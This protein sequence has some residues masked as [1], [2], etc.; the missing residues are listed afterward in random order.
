MRL[1]HIIQR[2]KVGV[3]GHSRR[4]QIVEDVRHGD[5]AGTGLDHD[6]TPDTWFRH[7][8][9]VSPR[10]PHLESIEF[11]NTHKLSIPDW[12]DAPPQ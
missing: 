4:A 6:W 3:S 1:A 9:V 2:L 5:L 11:E 8:D 10:T 12:D 7:H